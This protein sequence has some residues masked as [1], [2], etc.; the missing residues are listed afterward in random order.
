LA[1][2][3]LAVA[4]GA[5]VAL[6]A[7]CY[8]PRYGP[9]DVLDLLVSLGAATVLVV[10][11]G[12]G[13]FEGGEAGVG[14]FEGGEDRRQTGRTPRAGPSPPRP[15]GAGARETGRQG[16]SDPAALGID[17]WLVRW[18]AVAG[19]DAVSWWVARLGAAGLLS[20]LAFGAVGTN[21]AV[22]A[23]GAVVVLALSSVAPSGHRLMAMALGTVATAGALV[24][25][26]GI[27]ALL[28]G[29]LATSLV[30]PE[31]GFPRSGSLTTTAVHSATAVVL[32]CL[33]ATCVLA[34]T[35]AV[36][37]GAGA[38]AKWAIWAGVGTAVLCWGLAVP[39]LVRAGGLSS[40]TVTARG[41]PRALTA[42]LTVV[43]GPLWGP[44][45]AEMARW[46]IFATCLTGALG[47][48]GAGTGVAGKA[49]CVIRC[50]GSGRLGAGAQAE[51]VPP[52][53]GTR[54]VPRG[55]PAA[56]AAMATGLLAAAS[57]LVGPRLWL[58]VALGALATGALALTALAPPLTRQPQRL[59]RRLRVAVAVVWALAVTG[60]L[61]AA[62]PWALAGAGVVVL[63]AAAVA[64]PK[65]LRAAVTAVFGTSRR[66]RSKQL[67]RAVSTL[68][69]RALPA[70][71]GA[72]EALAAGE[73]P[74]IPVSELAELKA[75]VRPLE[76]ALAREG[77][78]EGLT[79]LTGALVDASRQVARLAASVE[80]VACLDSNRLEELVEVRI[81]ALAHANR[82]LV[83]S[84]WRRRQLLD[85]TV[86]V[87]E[88]ERARIAANLHDGP[89]QRL[90]ALGLV[91]DRCRLRLD[92]DDNNGARD[93]VKRARTELSEEI[94]SLRQMM[95]ELRPPILD[96]GGLEAALQDH[97]SSWSTT[98]GIETRFEAAPHGLL[99]L[100]SE[101]VVYRVVQEALANV[102]KHSGADLTTVSLSQSG[103]GV[104][105]VV[106]DNGKGFDAPSQPDLLR[107]GHFGLVV[108]RE[109]V[110]LASGRFE[111]HSAPRTGTEVVVWL[112]TV[113]ARE[114]VEV[115]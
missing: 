2:P 13:S 78:S 95:S 62:G 94:R 48:A 46:V 114:P 63:T 102:A 80:T 79:G 52:R 54:L 26:S 96:E 99:S 55:H 14:S 77:H 8:L 85:R 60:T 39:A 32:F 110:E 42:A 23:A 70:L 50:A 68:A 22:Q 112:P 5:P 69:E 20:A 18:P 90:A 24:A 88:E 37:R 111:I 9:T 34:A 66:Q 53:P 51:D 67:G 101:T 98:S 43:L 45:A 92:R 107:G 109:R 76:A 49:L 3:G 28:R 38:K 73:Q 64:G 106:R 27:V 11:A 58:V 97:L 56:M 75:S 83:D 86:R 44:N 15:A 31:R 115:A 1:R 105:V 29:R 16:C 10:A 36:S 72:L 71:T 108:M 61:G 6:L 19:A 35:P 91:L 81:G 21:H 41:G 47:A 12:V 30:P 93:L 40:V 4:A 74:R 7:L 89:I 104:Q 82:N 113:S 65:R 33:L 57:A 103:N 25:G 59:P 17:R 100:E 87:A 84:Q